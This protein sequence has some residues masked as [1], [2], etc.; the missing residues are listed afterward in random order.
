[1][2]RIR[3]EP[4]VVTAQ[5]PD[6]CPIPHARTQILDRRQTEGAIV[7]N[8]YVV[9]IIRTDDGGERED[10]EEV[11]LSRILHYVSPAELERFEN[12]QFRLEAEAEAIAVRAEIE[13]LARRR[14]ETNARGA[15]GAGRGSRMLSGLAPP[16]EERIRTRGRP[17]GRRGRGGGGGRGLTMCHNDLGE[18][19]V[20]AASFAVNQEDEGSSPVIPETEDEEEEGAEGEDSEAQSQPSPGLMRSAF[21]ANSALSVSPVPR[22]LSTSTLHRTQEDD[23]DE[24]EEEAYDFPTPIAQQDQGPDENSH[25]RIKRLRIGSPDSSPHHH[26]SIA[27]PPPTIP[28][29]AFTQA[30]LFSDRSSAPDI[31]DSSPHAPADFTHSLHP[32]FPASASP[33]FASDSDDSIPAYPPST[34]SNHTLPPSERKEEYNSDSIRVH[35]SSMNHG[36]DDDDDADKRV[37]EAENEA[38]EEYVVEAIIEHYRE[39]DK[40]YYLVEWEGYQDSHDWLPEEELQG[41]REL[42]AEYHARIEMGKGKGK[43]RANAVR[44]GMFFK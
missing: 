21:V 3:K 12:E 34:A 14:L 20:D 17:R 37:A 38:A 7:R 41:A 19:L 43:G 32:S 30:V 36:D 26:L 28:T 22:R 31:L 9:Q 1:L 4:A 25:H 40:T 44:K 33:M 13:E 39:G 15:K 24:E 18:Q 29:E 42:V 6:D 5:P 35:T 27:S 16:L 23:D 10:M 11:D 2:W 8:Y